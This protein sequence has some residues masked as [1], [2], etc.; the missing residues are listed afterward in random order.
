MFRYLLVTSVLVVI[1]VADTDPV[2]AMCGD[3]CSAWEDLEKQCERD[4]GCWD[5]K[6]DDQVTKK[7]KCFAQCRHI[8]LRCYHAC[9]VV[10][11]AC[12]HDCTPGQT[13]EGCFFS[14]YDNLFNIV[15]P[16][17]PTKQVS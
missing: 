1:S 16:A 6:G 5:I 7:E 11:K 3:R 10:Y 13:P 14:C 2:V 9:V 17:L 15:K 4:K 12:A 8:P